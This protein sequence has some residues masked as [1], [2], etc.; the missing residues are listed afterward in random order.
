MG[1]LG[2]RVVLLVWSLCIGLWV[3]SSQG[4]QDAL[5]LP[6]SKATRGAREKS[7]SQLVLGFL[8]ILGFLG[9]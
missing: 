9:L 7:E 8:Q 2:L 1:G 4:S 5:G 6:C 3:L